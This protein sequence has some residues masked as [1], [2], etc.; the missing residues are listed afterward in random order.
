MSELYKFGWLPDGQNELP[1][2]YPDVWVR[3]SDDRMDRLA[4]APRSGYVELLEELAKTLGEPFLLLY[5][6]VVSRGKAEPGRYQ[7]EY[8]F[9]LDQLHQF[10][11]EYSDF[12]E[13]DARHNLWIRSVSGEGLLVY[14]RHNII[15][16][17][18]P[19]D[20]FITVLGTKGLTETRDQF[21]HYASPHVHHYHPEFDVYQD[22][23]L[24][25]I[26]WIASPLRP[27]DENPE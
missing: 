9:G 17:Y 26:K 21:L 5:V 13:N 3:E 10:L 20:K 4:I 1:Y 16:A 14:D 27:G 7:S 22:R 24:S 23:L 11:H 2:E 15:Y 8:S 6:L 12:F 19:R 25:E 18:G